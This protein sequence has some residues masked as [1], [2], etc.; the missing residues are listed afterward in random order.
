MY[1]T[2]IVVMFIFRHFVTFKCY[3]N[4]QLLTIYTCECRSAPAGMQQKRL[5]KHTCLITLVTEKNLSF[6]FFIRIDM[7]AIVML[8][9]SGCFC[10]GQY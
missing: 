10:T 9:L 4:K 2:S 6:L 8:C 3:T 5:Q 1:V 7:K